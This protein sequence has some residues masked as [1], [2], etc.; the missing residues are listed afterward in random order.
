MTQLPDTN[1]F[2]LFGGYNGGKM[3]LGDAF[4]LNLGILG[5]LK[6]GYRQSSRRAGID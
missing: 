3:P 6:F 4:L 5:S 1:R 2:L